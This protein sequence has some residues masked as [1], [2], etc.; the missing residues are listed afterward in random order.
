MELMR[1][2]I[3]SRRRRSQERLHGYA[4]QAIL[5]KIAYE[6]GFLIEFGRL[7][8]MF[9]VYSHSRLPAAISSSV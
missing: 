9:E 3:M 2:R 7:E 8:A 6:R 5:A 4:D 1:R